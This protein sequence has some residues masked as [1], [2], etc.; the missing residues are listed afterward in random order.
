MSILKG[1]KK[2]VWKSCTAELPTDKTKNLFVHFS[3]LFEKL[4]KS[5]YKALIK[6]NDGK[7][8]RPELADVL[9]KYIKDWKLKGEDDVE[10]PFTEEYIEEVFEDMDYFKGILDGFIEVH[11]RNYQELVRKN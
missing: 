10:V 6:D 4:S 3:V 7:N 2:Q 8:G 11:V 5:D 9:P 1:A